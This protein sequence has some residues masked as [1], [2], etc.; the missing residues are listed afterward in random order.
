LGK[1]TFTKI[2]IHTVYS[3][4]LFFAITS[5]SVN[6]MQI[7]NDKVCEIK[8]TSR[9]GNFVCHRNNENKREKRHRKNHEILSK[10]YF[11]Y[12]INL[13]LLLMP[14]EGRK[15]NK[16]ELIIKSEAEK[17]EKNGG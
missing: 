14:C 9:Y 3:V 4:L 10:Y 8:D 13:M 16:S 6:F 15:E 1:T 5:S 11:H 7:N 17:K 2:A 12:L